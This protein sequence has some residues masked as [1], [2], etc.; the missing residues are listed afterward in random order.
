MPEKVWMQAAGMFIPEANPRV[1]V[2]LL[3]CDEAD[4]GQGANW[5]RLVAVTELI[6]LGTCLHSADGMRP[7]RTAL[8]W[9]LWPHIGC[10]RSC[11]EATFSN[12]CF[13]YIYAC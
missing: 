10:Y 12:D 1:L 9:C 11:A 4:A 7:H 5:L 3:T 6:R 8:C 2:G 13:F